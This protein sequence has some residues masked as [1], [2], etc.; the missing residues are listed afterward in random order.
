[1]NKI[2]IK[3]IRNKTMLTIFI[4]ITIIGGLRS[5][6]DVKRNDKIIKQDN[7]LSSKII[8]KISRNEI[9]K[10]NKLFISTSYLFTKSNTVKNMILNNKKDDLKI[11]SK[12]ITSI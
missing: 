12:N 3:Q 11:Y 1:M 5:Y 10:L 6:E 9:I 2:R 7:I 8:Q 4:I